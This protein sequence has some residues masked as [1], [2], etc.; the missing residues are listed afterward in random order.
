M[1]ETSAGG[2][3]SEQKVKVRK[4]QVVWTSSENPVFRVH[5]GRGALP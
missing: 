1:S 3:C 5:P 2:R 4:E